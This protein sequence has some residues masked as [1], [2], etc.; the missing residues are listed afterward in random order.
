MPK[1]SVTSDKLRQSVEVSQERLFEV[2]CNQNL[3][4][5]P[6]KEL[7]FIKSDSKNLTDRNHCQIDFKS[8]ARSSVE[9]IAGFKKAL[10]KER[11]RPMT[12]VVDST[13]STERADV[14]SPLAKNAILSQRGKSALQDGTAKRL[15]TSS[16]KAHS[17]K[18]GEPLQSVRKSAHAPVPAPEYRLYVKKNSMLRQ[19]NFLKSIMQQN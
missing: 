19:S 8:S 11:L 12:G 3:Q 6:S 15:I 4:A 9:K 16:S 14:C 13:K 2:S 1:E 18:K 17:E 5:S 7:R 10:G